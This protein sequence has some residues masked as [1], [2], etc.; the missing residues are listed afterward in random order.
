MRGGACVSA[1]YLM[2]QLGPSNEKHALQEHR[3][4]PRWQNLYLVRYP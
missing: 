1:D 2:A 3:P 4:E